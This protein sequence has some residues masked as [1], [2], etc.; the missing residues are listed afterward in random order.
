MHN[1]LS[2]FELL[3]IIA[4]FGIVINHFFNKAIG[5]YGNF[6]IDVS[7]IG[8]FSLWFVLEIMKL[9]ALPSVNCYILI[10]GYFMIQRSDFRWKGTLK[11]WAETLFYSVSIT[12]LFLLIGRED[13]SFDTLKC[14]F[15]L[16]SNEYWFI[17]TYVM[18]MLFSPFIS[19]LA[20]HISKR[21]YQVLLVFGTILCFEYPFGQYFL[22]AQQLFLFILLFLIGGYIRL[23]CNDWTDIK[24]PFISSVAVLMLMFAY[25]IAKNL[26]LDHNI[27]TVYAMAYNGLVLPLSVCVFMLFKDIRI[28]NKLGTYIN[29]I[30]PLTLAVYLIHEQP[31]FSEWMW[32]TVKA[33]IDGTSQIMLPV[34]CLI[35][36]TIIFV[37]SIIVDKIVRMSLHLC[38][39]SYKK[40]GQE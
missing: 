39:M 28:G 4:M 9:M 13:F 22:S 17:S 24:K 19:I 16:C 2:N 23:Y 8:G 10:T 7:D 14:L 29:A 27:F 3:R 5:I 12:V 21:Q 11:V 34:Q 20:S 31:L 30:S 25:T 6:G 18:L 1:R 15:P 37:G 26:W 36:S 35:I 33:S 38:Y 40:L 32:P